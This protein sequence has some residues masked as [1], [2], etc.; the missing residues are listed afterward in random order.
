MQ[1]DVTNL[2][3]P[4]QSFDLVVCTEV[5]EHIKPEKLSTACNELSRVGKKYLLIG[6]PYNQ[7][8][9]AHATKCKNCG[10]INPTCG[11]VNSFI[12]KKLYSLFPGYIPVK[13]EFVGEK[14]SRTN[15]LSYCIYKYF[16]FPYGSYQQEEPCINCNQNLVKPQLSFFAKI[17]CIGAMGLEVIQNKYFNRSYRPNWIHVLFLKK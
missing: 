1:G 16:H 5:L 3:L 4:D 9:R 7:D 8:L 17:V 13:N 2:T 10:T 11:H 15:R 6:V 12:D 14:E